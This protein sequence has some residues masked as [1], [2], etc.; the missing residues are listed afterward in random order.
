MK[1]LNNRIYDEL[2]E[3]KYT[4]CI[5]SAS[6][7]KEQKNKKYLNGILIF[8]SICSVVGWFKFDELKF[9]WSIILIC[10]QAIRIFQNSILQSD[11]ELFSMKS[12]IDFYEYNLMELENLFYDY[13]NSKFKDA[14]IEKRLNQI[15][16]EERNLFSR[17]NFEK[18]KADID[19]IEKAE[20]ETD[21]YLTKLKNNLV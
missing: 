15:R 7:S 11:T 8:I 9:V 13:H 17:Q 4:Q 21:T 14:T 10:T 5:L 18:I 12:S 3:W 6:L 2:N 19:L 16:T 20:K 1:N